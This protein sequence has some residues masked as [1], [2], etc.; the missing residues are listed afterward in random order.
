MYCALQAACLHCRLTQHGLEAPASDV[1]FE[2]S[3]E[4][5]AS[6]ALQRLRSEE[7]ADGSTA[8]KASGQQ[9]AQDRLDGEG[10]KGTTPRTSQVACIYGSAASTGALFCRS[11]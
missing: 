10:L 5:A 1:S 8:T 3:D 11:H 2:A 9:T 4:R 7:A 6:K